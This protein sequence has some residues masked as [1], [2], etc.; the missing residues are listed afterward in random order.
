MKFSLCERAVQICSF[1]GILLHLP[2][3]EYIRLF[4][5]FLLY[6]LILAFR[7]PAYFE[8]LVSISP[9]NA[10]VLERVSISGQKT[11]RFTSSR[12][13]LSTPRRFFGLRADTSLFPAGKGKY[14]LGV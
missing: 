7:F 4:E 13:S 8:V 11:C 10:K 2:V 14:W 12:L 9:G 3:Q 6:R 1:L 5:K